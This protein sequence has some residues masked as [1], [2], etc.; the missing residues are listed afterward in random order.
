VVAPLLLEPEADGRL[1]R[2]SFLGWAAYRT[3][4]L[5]APEPA[6]A[7][8]FRAQPSNGTWVVDSAD[9]GTDFLTMTA[10]AAHFWLEGDLAL[11]AGRGGLVF[12]FAEDGGGYFVRLRTDSTSV[13]LVKWLGV[14]QSD[15]NWFRYAEIQHGELMKPLRPSVPIRFQLL[16]VGPYLNAVSTARSCWPRSAPSGSR[17]PRESGLN[18]AGLGPKTCTGRRCGFRS[19]ADVSKRS[20]GELVHPRKQPLV[21]E[22]QQT[23]AETE[24]RAASPD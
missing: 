5:A 18:R 2:R 24:H 14:A 12:R 3:A 10:A 8:A 15:R 19:T 6:E 11:S 7:T 22:N 13:T 17:D 20:S 4:P 1:V 16:V 21:R 23:E 9:G